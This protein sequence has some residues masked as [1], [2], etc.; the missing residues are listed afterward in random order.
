MTAEERAQDVFDNSEIEWPDPYTVRI[1]KAGIVQALRDQI[2]E[3]ARKADDA[4]STFH[5]KAMREAVESVAEE[6]RAMAK[7]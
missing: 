5:H 6:I 7:H 3:C 1:L 2:E 4:S